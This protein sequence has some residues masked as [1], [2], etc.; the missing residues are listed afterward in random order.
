MTDAGKSAYERA[1]QIE[2]ESYSGAT[3]RPDFSRGDPHK[4]GRAAPT[5]RATIIAT[6]R[7][8]SAH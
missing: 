8:S 5:R 3:I 1:W 2:R 6:L 7:A 4:F